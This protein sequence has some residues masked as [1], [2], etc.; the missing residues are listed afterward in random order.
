MHEKIILFSSRDPAGRNIAK[1]LRPGNILEVE[2]VPQMN[3]T[4]I[5][6]DLFI[7]ASRHV[8]KSQTPTLTCHSP[9]NY[10]TADSGK[11]KELSIAPALYLR[12]ALMLLKSSKI[13]YKLDYEVSL[14]C[15]HHGPTSLNTPILFVEVGSTMKEW[16]DLNACRAAAEVINELLLYNPEEK[17]KSAVAFGGG[18]YCRKFS[19]IEEYAIGH[20]CPKYNLQN[21]DK[22]MIEQMIEKTVPKPTVALAE[23]KGLGKEKKRILELLEESGLE[24]VLV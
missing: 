16:S 13:K 19:E 6:A 8:S 1:Q 7:V 15:T 5:E 17:I 3:E 18:H 10:Y 23:R 2:N 24:L 22:S 14:E 20:I 12:K 11:P 21:L 4:G 9:G